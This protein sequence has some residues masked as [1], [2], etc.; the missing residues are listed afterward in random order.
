[1]VLCD[2]KSDD[3]RAKEAQMKR[4]VVLTLVCVGFAVLCQAQSLDGLLKRIPSGGSIGGGGGALDDSTVASG[5]KEALTIGTGNAV[6]SGS[7]VDGYFKNQIIKI[8]LPEKMQTAA[9]VLGKLGYQKQV[10]DFVLSMNRAAENA[11]PKAKD[12]FVGA[13]KE[14]TIQDATKILK[15]S[16]TAATDYFKSKTSK[17]LYDEFKPPVSESMNKVGVTKS[18]KDMVGTYTSKVPFAKAESV[19]LDHYVTT[20]SIDGLFYLIAQEEKKIRTNPSA[21][22]TD[23]L[24]QVF[25][26]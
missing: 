19:D 10:D 20:K 13:I 14:M 8:L 16:D 24:K 11:A 18:Y 7:Q 25:G 15:G 9:N 23:L 26:K 17:K 22:V 2:G 4:I 12:I 1:M 6:T 21:R 5:L 3:R